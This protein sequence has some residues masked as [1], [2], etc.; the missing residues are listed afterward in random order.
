[1]C[2]NFYQVC[3]ERGDKWADEVRTRLAGSVSDLHA[4]G[5]R[6]HDCCYKEFTSERNIAA[7]RK[8]TCQGGIEQ[9][10]SLQKVLQYLANNKGKPFS[11]TE[12]VSLYEQEGGC[13][14][15]KYAIMQKVH[16]YFGSDI[17]V[18]RSSGFANVVIFRSYANKYLKLDQSSESQVPLTEFA[19]QVKH[20][21]KDLYYDSSCYKRELDEKTLADDCSKTILNFLAKLSPSL[22]HTAAA[23]LIGSIITSAIMHRPT[24]LQLSLSVLLRDKLLIDHLE[25]FKVCSTYK[26]FLQFRTSVAVADSVLKFCEFFLPAEQGLVQSIIDNFDLTIFT[27]NGNKETHDLAII[28]TQYG[29]KTYAPLRP[30]IPRIPKRKLPQVDI[31]DAV[32]YSC[33][34]TKTSLMPENVVK[35]PVL[36]LRVL[37]MQFLSVDQA[38]SLDFMFLQNITV[39]EG[40]PEYSG[41]NTKLN[42]GS[43]DPMP[44]TKIFFPPLINRSPKD[45]ATIYTAMK[46]SMHCAKETGQTFAVLSADQDIYKVVISILWAYPDEFNEKNFIPRIGGLHWIMSFIGCIGSLMKNTGLEDVLSQVFGSVPKMLLGKLYPNNFRALRLFVEVLLS[47]DIK[48]FARKEDLYEHLEEISKRSKTSA[49]WVQNVVKPVFLIM[50]FVRAEREGDWLLHLYSCWEMMPYFYAAN[51]GN[52]ARYGLIYIMYMLRMKDNIREK[53]MQGQ[54]V[55]RHIKGC[56][57][58]TWS[59]MLME[60][61]AIRQGKGN[62]RQGG[63]VGKTVRPE[64][65]KKSCISFHT[66]LNIKDDLQKLIEVDDK[67]PGKHKEEQPHRLQLDKKD[68]ANLKA[69]LTSCLHPLRPSTHAETNCIV[70]IFTGDIADDKVNIHQSVEIGTHMM[71]TFCASLPDGFKKTI[72][73]KTVFFTKPKVVHINERPVVDTN[74]IFSRAMCLISSG[75][76]DIKTIFSHELCSFPPS[77]FHQN[78]EPRYCTTKSTLKNMLERTVSRRSSLSPDYIIIDACALLW[79]ISWPS[80][81][82]VKDFADLVMAKVCSYATSAHVYVVFDRYY[83]YSIKSCTRQRRLSYVCQEVD[84][85]LTTPLPSQSVLLK[86]T[87]NKIKLIKLLAEYLL[88]NFPEDSPKRLIVTSGHPTPKQVFKGSITE[89]DDLRTTHEEADVIIPRQVIS[90]MHE[91]ASCVRVICDDT[92]VFLLLL[93]TLYPFNTTVTVQMDSPKNEDR[94]LVDI[95][96]TGLANKDLVPCLL[97][98]HSISGCDTVPQ[99]YGIGKKRVLKTLNSFPLQNLGDDKQDFENILSESKSFI[100]ACYG[101]TEIS[102]TTFADIR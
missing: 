37:C 80:A 13:S 78:G 2:Y 23:F 88:Q 75:Q 10:M 29:S 96:K 71:K 47:N 1:M 3:D 12:I 33:K 57:N 42:R 86:F 17:V 92:D 76:L 87:K 4:A 26:E 81:G 34:N 25:K 15:K 89:R 54:H 52:Y 8:A 61:T 100:A 82:S 64:Q 65:V 41:Y 45:P 66:F 53:F 97:A 58:G 18:L 79:T 5:G 31:P 50:L 48:S 67:Y 24:S 59:D 32:V 6:Y 39:S 22:D 46:N 30:V 20:E 60:T 56:W 14:T 99:Y 16:D 62:L 68:R 27:P 85:K 101:I 90:A 63:L 11:S 44:A 49:A 77:L 7:A 91:G 35:L 95:I 51:H 83:E 102:S 38:K 94:G 19:K 73:R 84:L 98:A 55:M 21:V 72:S 9:D 74:V 40:V 70:N 69:V 93:H 36:P 43:S 28:H